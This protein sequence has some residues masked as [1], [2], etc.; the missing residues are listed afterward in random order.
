MATFRN[1]KNKWQARVRR[2]GQPD[3]TKTFLTKTDA[4]KWARSIEIEIDR[5]TFINTSYAQKTLFKDLIQQYLKEVTPTLRGAH[6]DTYRLRKMMRNPIAELNLTELTPNKIAN[7]RDER[8]KEIK[9]NTVIRELTYI[10]SMIN[11]ARREWGLG[12]SNPVAQIRKPSQPQGRERILND[13]EMDRILHEVEKLNPFMKPLCK[14]A[15]ETAM[16]RGELLSLNWTNIDFIKRT[17]HLKITKNGSSRFV[18]LSTE[19]IKILNLIP[20]DINGKVFPLKANTV[21]MGFIK[22][23]RRSK[24]EDFHFHDLRHMALTKLSN[25][26]TNVLELAAISGH[27]ELKMLQRYVHFKAEDL[28]L[29]LI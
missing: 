10:S 9:P 7:Y 20:R 11:H 6:E 27:K 23:V 14:F 29:K 25:K 2:C 15:L 5:G 13:V 19:A 17:A 18:P 3:V 4:E 16:R 26:F 22:A 28:A 21:S 12:I 8:L 24:V 1:R